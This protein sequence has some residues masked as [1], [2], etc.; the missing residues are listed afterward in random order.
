MKD[1]VIVEFKQ[2]Q[3]QALSDL[4]DKSF[5]DGV[6]SVPASPSG[7]SAEQEAADIAAAVAQ[8]EARL[9][10]EVDA[11]KLEASQAMALKDAIKAKLADLLAQL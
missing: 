7:V 4:Y 5:N 1:E 2:A 3:D 6:A 10:D 11:A 8:V 9:H